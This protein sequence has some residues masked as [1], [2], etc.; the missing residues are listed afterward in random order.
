M[1]LW[2]KTAWWKIWC[3]LWICEQLLFSW[4]LSAESKTVESFLKS[5]TQDSSTAPVWKI[6]TDFWTRH[7]WTERWE[8]VIFL[9]DDSWSHR[10]L[11]NSSCRFVIL[12]CLS[13]NDLIVDASSDIRHGADRVSSH[14]RR[15]DSMS[16]NAATSILIQRL[17]IKV[18]QNE[19]WQT[20]GKKEAIFQSNSRFF[21]STF[22]V[23]SATLINLLSLQKH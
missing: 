3:S 17:N 6:I 16:S 13:V 10:T 7:R 2:S 12:Q 8:T 5:K 21:S 23:S 14:R 19:S 18:C 4:T 9:S 15:I 1:R 20:R 11:I 22:G